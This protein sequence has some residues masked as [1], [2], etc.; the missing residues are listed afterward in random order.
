MSERICYT[1]LDAWK[2]HILSSCIFTITTAITETFTCI[3]W[4]W[5]VV[6]H[7]KISTSRNGKCLTLFCTS[8]AVV[9]ETC[10]SIFFFEIRRLIEL[11][12][13]FWIF[14]CRER[15][16]TI[17]YFHYISRYTYDTLYEITFFWTYSW[18]KYHYI[19]AI[20]TCNT[21][22][23]FIHEYKFSIA[24]LLSFC[25]IGDITSMKS[26][27][28]WWPYDLERRE[29][30]GTDKKYQNKYKAEINPGIKTNIFYLGMMTIRMPISPK[31]ICCDASDNRRHKKNKLHRHMHIIETKKTH[32]NNGNK[33]VEK[34]LINSRKPSMVCV[35]FMVFHEPHQEKRGEGQC[36]S[37]PANFYTESACTLPRDSKISPNKYSQTQ[38]WSYIDTNL[39]KIYASTY[40]KN[41]ARMYKYIDRYKEQQ[42]N[43]YDTIDIVCSTDFSFKREK[44]IFQNIHCVI[45]EIFMG[46]QIVVSGYDIKIPFYIYFIKN[47]P[48]AN[49][50][51]KKSGNDKFFI[52]LLSQS[53]ASSSLFPHDSI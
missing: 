30:V 32:Q 33:Y 23:H 4:L 12:K 21:I 2:W 53:S 47:R 5:S 15:N 16:I 35:F 42:N 19:S 43:V 37:C 26:S 45:I 31:E 41:G 38:K 9:S 39:C 50:C 18:S 22:C 7:E 36:E 51:Y 34:C 14:R 24:V 44:D 49:I 40:E 29:Y 25:C 17:F 28:H 27:L 46:V 11:Y 1:S 10:I 48:L 8:C 13:L 52:F 20:R 6:A 3:E